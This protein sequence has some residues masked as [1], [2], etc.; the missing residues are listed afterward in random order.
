VPPS[1]ASSCHHDFDERK[2]RAGVCGRVR[3]VRQ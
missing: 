1:R 2:K 3:C